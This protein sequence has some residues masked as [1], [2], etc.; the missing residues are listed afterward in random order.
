MLLPRKG[1]FVFWSHRVLKWLVPFDLIIVFVIS[2]I[3]AS[4]SGLMLLLLV[5]QILIYLAFVLYYFYVVKK[6]KKPHGGIS[7]IISLAFYFMSINLA[8]FIGWIKYISG[9]QKA[10]WETQ[11]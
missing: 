11:R 6:D 9:K 1:S 7:K 3:L 8:L 2:A 4:S 5:V 10:T